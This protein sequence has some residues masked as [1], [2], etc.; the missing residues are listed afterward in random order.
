VCGQPGSGK[1]VFTLMQA[2]HAA[3]TW[4]PVGVI[5]LEMGRNRLAMRLL[6]MHTDYSFHE[7]RSGVRRDGEPFGDRERITLANAYER[8]G[9]QLA[10]IQVDCE[11]YGLDALVG[12]VRRLRLQHGIEAVIVDYGQL[13]SAPAGNRDR[14][15]EL[16]YIGRSLKNRVAVPFRMP[17]W[18]LVQPNQESKRVGRDGKP[19]LLQPGDMFGGMEW[20]A[21]ANQVW[22]LN[23]DP[24]S[25][26][27]EP[28]VSE[29]RKPI[30]L[31]VH[32]SRDGG[33]GMVPLTLVGERF[34][35]VPRTDRYGDSPYG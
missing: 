9:S 8:L 1:T 23:R 24:Q 16:G 28:G 21:V 33:T 25:P 17:V 27:P 15:Q 11:S 6:A 19:R 29:P 4:G 34:T 26:P 3:A 31:H 35:F 20:E 10:L 22:F 2:L 32:K 12:T 18:C 13:V 14:W 30:L 5:S 7:I